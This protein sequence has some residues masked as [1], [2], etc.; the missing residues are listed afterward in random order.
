MKN[1]SVPVTSAT[2]SRAPYTT[3][4]WG[5]GV[6]PPTHPN[7]LFGIKY[8]EFSESLAAYRF[9]LV[10]NPNLMSNFFQLRAKRPVRGLEVGTFSR[11]FNVLH[12]TPF[13]ETQRF[14]FPIKS[15][16][17]LKFCADSEYRI[18]FLWWGSYIWDVCPDFGDFRVF[19]SFCLLNTCGCTIFI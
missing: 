11:F 8:F 3:S 12:M 15:F 16:Q 4:S 2:G 9:L 6:T 18:G 1:S 19:C 7:D 17:R 5:W 14:E 10:L 13:L